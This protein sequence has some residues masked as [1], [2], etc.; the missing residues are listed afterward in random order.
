MS[1]LFSC[2]DGCAVVVRE[3]HAGYEFSLV[4]P[5]LPNPLICN[6]GGGQ[7]YIYYYVLKSGMRKD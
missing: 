1:S 3:G 2:A 7:K 5:E 4:E 6:M